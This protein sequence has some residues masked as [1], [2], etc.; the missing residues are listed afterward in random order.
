M[1]SD[2]RPETFRHIGDCLSEEG[3]LEQT[4]QHYLQHHQLVVLFDSINV[5]AVAGA[6]TSLK[7]MWRKSTSATCS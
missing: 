1:R 6:R 5:K 3:N 2:R 7:S 4:L